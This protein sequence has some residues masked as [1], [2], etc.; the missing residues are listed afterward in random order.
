MYGIIQYYDQVVQEWDVDLLQY[1]KD[2]QI[3]LL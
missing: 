2:K 1:T 3:L